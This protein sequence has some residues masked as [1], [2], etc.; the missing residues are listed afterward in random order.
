MRMTNITRI[1]VLILTSL[2]LTF[3]VSMAKA[4]TNESVSSEAT[5]SI[6]LKLDMVAAAGAGSE[7]VAGKPTIGAKQPL[8]PFSLNVKVGALF[9][10]RESND[11]LALVTNSFAP[12]GTVLLNAND[13]NLGYEIVAD[14]SLGVKLRVFGTAFGI[15]GRYFGLTEWGKSRGPFQSSGGAVVQFQTPVGNTFFPANISAKYESYLQS[16]ELNLSW[17]PIEER[18][19]AINGLNVLDKLSVF[20]GGRFLKLDEAIKITQDI[21]PGLNTATYKIPVKNKLW[22]GQFGI[23]AVPLRIGGLS[24]EGWAKL[25][26]L[27]ND[28]H[29]RAQI[30][31]N[32][33]PGFFAAADKDKSTWATEFGIGVKYAFNRYVALSARYQ[34]LWLDKVALSPQQMPVSD[35][36][37]GRA[38]VATDSVLYQGAWVGIVIS[39]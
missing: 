22:G 21:G 2:T 39:L 31:Q 25:I 16:A 13:L 5:P 38:T 24:I 8:S 7:A 30:T 12:G 33:G 26:Y 32:V 29:T 34:L 17:H 6:N 1:V 35:P 23:E 36:F 4:E 18:L 11:D 10:H 20:I 27:N 15:E 9:L 19:I 37:V 14:V 3:W 28:M